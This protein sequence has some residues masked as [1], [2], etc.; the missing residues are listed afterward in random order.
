M[1]RRFKTRFK[2]QHH[3]PQQN[4]SQ[5]LKP[6]RNSNDNQA[7]PSS[8]AAASTPGL[9]DQFDGVGEAFPDT[10]EVPDHWQVAYDKLNETERRLLSAVQSTAQPSSSPLETEKVLDEVVRITKEQYLEYEKGGL[11]IHRSGGQHIDLREIARKILNST[12]TFKNVITNIVA[13]DPTGHASSAWGVV[14]LGLTVRNC[15]RPPWG[16]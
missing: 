9:S 3:Q 16:G 12:L 1:F 5:H 6:Q 13:F 4:Q 2:R 10:S 8:S 7:T 14:S 11:K 15:D